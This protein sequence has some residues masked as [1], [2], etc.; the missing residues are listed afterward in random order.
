VKGSDTYLEKNEE[1]IEE[2]QT[3]TIT[4]FDSLFFVFLRELKYSKV[5]M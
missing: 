3:S 5:Y 4:P 2:K 1:S